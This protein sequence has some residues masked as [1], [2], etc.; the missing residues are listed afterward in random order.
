MPKIKFYH[1]DILLCTYLIWAVLNVFVAY[2]CCLAVHLTLKSIPY[3]WAILNIFPL[4][5]FIMA[6]WEGDMEGFMIFL[7]GIVGGLAVV[8]GVLISKQWAR[9]LIIIGM[10]IWFLVGV[11]ALGISV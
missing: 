8:V 6:L 3:Y 1:I 4:W 7:T 5:G 10:T 11:L 2:N 9:F